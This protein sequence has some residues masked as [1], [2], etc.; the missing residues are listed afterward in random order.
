MN[1]RTQATSIS[2]KVRQTVIAR[3][4][5]CIFCGSH[6]MLSVAHYIP[7]SK[8]GKGIEQNLALACM[9]CHMRL[10]QSVYRK[11]VLAIMERYLISHYGVLENIIYKKGE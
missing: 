8:G 6:Q 2:T 11:E 4:K 5:H 7:R 10:D 9:P 3:D 1:K